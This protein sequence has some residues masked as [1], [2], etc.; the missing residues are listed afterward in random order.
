MDILP[1]FKLD[2]RCNVT[3]DT[4]G[5]DTLDRCLDKQHWKKYPYP[6]TYTFNSRGYRDAE[7]PENLQDAVWCVGDSFTVGVGQP[8]EHIWP[9]VLSQR[10]GQRTINVSM[11]GAS[12]EYIRDK[13][14]AICKTISPRYVVVQWSY[15]H[16][17]QK[18]D[19]TLTDEE[20]RIHYNEIYNPEVFSDTKNT[21]ECINSVEHC[22]QSTRVIHSFVPLFVGPKEHIVKELIKK[23]FA[24]ALMTT[25]NEQ[26]DYARDY[27]HYDILTVNRYVERYCKFMS[28][29]T[30][31]T[32]AR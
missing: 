28:F 6:I 19:T 17:R 20:R 2:S 32:V 23:T 7:W 9:V 13:V 27:H 25:D 3:A 8:Y 12:N 5:M 10:T 1:D 30:Q 21:I 16:R 26:V 18:P 29:D 11:E 24:N 14:I 22:K 31:S 15:T 4:H